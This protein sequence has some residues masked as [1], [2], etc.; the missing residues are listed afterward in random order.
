[1]KA[2]GFLHLLK[3]KDVVSFLLFMMDLLS[4]LKSM[5]LVL[6]EETAVLAVQHRMIEITLEGIKKLETR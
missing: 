3:S 1:M 2:K 5:S 4:S 6:Q